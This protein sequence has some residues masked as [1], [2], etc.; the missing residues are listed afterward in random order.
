MLRREHMPHL[1]GAATLAIIFSATSVHP[2][3]APSGSGGSSSMPSSSG[4][5]GQSADTSSQSSSQSAGAA[6]GG[7][8]S[9]ADSNYL[10]A[11][12]NT[13]LAEIEAGKL[14]QSKTKNSQVRDYAQHMIDDHTKGL[15]EVQKVAQAKGVKLP[16]EPDAKHKEMMKKLSA[17]SGDQFDRQYMAQG[18]VRDHRQAD[19]MLK[20][21]QTQASDPDVKSLAK[22][23]EG[24]VDQHLKLAEQMSKDMKSG[25]AATGTSGTAGSSGGSSK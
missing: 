10:R 24:T 19:A 13:N 14:A 15:S 9:K 8:L 7:G 6:K 11:M 20:K 4:A 23:M 5:S 3:P 21:A 17:M 1:L 2:Q 16:T 12:A 22:T 18:G 25:G